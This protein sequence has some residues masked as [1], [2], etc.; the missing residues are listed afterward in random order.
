[1]KLLVNVLKN[2]LKNLVKRM[3]EYAN[4]QIFYK[5]RTKKYCPKLSSNKGTMVCEAC[6]IGGLFE[7]SS[8][9]W[10]YRCDIDKLTKEGK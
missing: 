9:S 3:Y 7:N 4:T 6:L 5:R 8:M 2:L 1:M 10:E